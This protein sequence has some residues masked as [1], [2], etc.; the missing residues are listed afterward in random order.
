[1]AIESSRK[2]EVIKDH[3]RAE[4]DNGSAEVQIALLTEDIKNL[5]EHLKIHKK[6]FSTRRGLLAKVGRRS[7]LLRYLRNKDVNRYRELIASLGLR[8]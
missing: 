5:T 1:M 7:R 8:R 2:A 4:G 6:D 3:A